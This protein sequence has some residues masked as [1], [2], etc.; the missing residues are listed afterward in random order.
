MPRIIKIE[1]QQQS[2]QNNKYFILKN[3]LAKD[4]CKLLTEKLIE[5]VN[6]GFT[7]K[8]NQCPTSE[9]IYGAAEFDN[10]LEALK[11]DLE[12]YTGKRL[13]PTYSY[14]RL[15]KKGEEL[16]IHRDRPSCEISVTLALGFSNKIWPIYFGYNENKY[17][18]IKTDLDI[19]D[20][21]V[22]KGEEIYHWREKLVESEWTAQVFL[23]YVDADGPYKDYKFD[24]RESLGTKVKTDNFNHAVIEKNNENIVDFLCFE[25]FFDDK[26]CEAIINSY[27]KKDLKKEKGKVGGDEGDGKIAE[28][29][30][31]VEKISIS[32]VSGLGGRL[33]GVGL[34]ANFSTWKFNI[35]QCNQSE[36]LIYPEGGKYNAH[37][38][39]FNRPG[40]ELTRKLTVLAFLNDDFEGGKFWLDTSGKVYPSQK[41]GTVLVFP[42]YVLHCV[43]PVT[44][45]TRYSAVAWMVGPWFK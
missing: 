36:F 13:H 4:S 24:K 10:L 34:F 11:Y 18:P 9:A 37:V 21:V 43:E 40:Y 8:D 23:H 15:Y 1:G 39:T 31:N 35:D 29:I 45:G 38:D 30:R 41:K 33:A 14:A 2:L 32:P 25:N 20:A 6:S 42:S 7:V 12:K 44:K 22:Y 17:N 28:S 16:K 26:A 19:G 3:F 5:Y 27:T